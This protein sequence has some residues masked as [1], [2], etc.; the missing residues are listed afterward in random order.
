M[1]TEVMEKTKA[2][3]LEPLA[4]FIQD[5]CL[6]IVDGDRMD[7]ERFARLVDIIGNRVRFCSHNKVTDFEFKIG[8]DEYSVRV[9]NNL[10]G[11][12]SVSDGTSTGVSHTEYKPFWSDEE[13][14][15]FAGYCSLAQMVSEAWYHCVNNWD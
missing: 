1:S 2:V 9:N 3:D 10:H 7:A 6:D 4:E 11:F 14:G 5:E 15:Y 12:V 8:G 13:D